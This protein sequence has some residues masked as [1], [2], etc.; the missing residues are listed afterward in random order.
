VERVGAA[1]AEVGPHHLGIRSDDF[2]LLG[3]DITDLD[4]K[5]SKRVTKLFALLRS[6]IAEAL[7]A[8]SQAALKPGSLMGP[9]GSQSRGFATTTERLRRTTTR[10]AHSS[11]RSL[12]I[13]LDRTT[14]TEVPIPARQIARSGAVTRLCN[15]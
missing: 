9:Q 7:E 13:F 3:R 11:W 14:G 5:M 10:W 1:I 2:D 8:D 12:R 6:A 4:G 15:G